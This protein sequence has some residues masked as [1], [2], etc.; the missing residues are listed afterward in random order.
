MFHVREVVSAQEAGYVADLVI[1]V[2]TQV[3]RRIPGNYFDGDH[4]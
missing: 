3:D 1:A 2:G 4:V